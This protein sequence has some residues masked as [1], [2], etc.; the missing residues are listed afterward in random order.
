VSPARSASS[1]AVLLATATY[2]AVAPWSCD[3]DGWCHGLLAFDY[4]PG[5]PKQAQAVAAAVLVAAVTW[6]LVWLAA[7]PERATPR[8]L[9]VGVS[10]VLVVA[11][12]VSL[13]SH[14][15]LVFAGPLVTATFLWLL[16]GRDPGGR[17]TSGV[18]VLAVLVAIATL[19]LLFPVSTIMQCS[20]GCEVVARR[21]A[22]G[23]DVPRSFT[24]IVPGAIVATGLVVLRRRR[25]R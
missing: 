23:L 25:L 21:S 13:V 3:V 24:Y 9:R 6:L 19:V 12:V 20:A 5:S 16:W 18:V 7:S 17:A 15:V 14:S 2:A 22:A 10:A 4:A 1:G 8:G 11:G